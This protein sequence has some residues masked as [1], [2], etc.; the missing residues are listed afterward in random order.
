MYER[1]KIKH[2]TPPSD[3]FTEACFCSQKPGSDILFL[4]KNHVFYHHF[5]LLIVVVACY[6]HFFILFHHAYITYMCE[7]VCKCNFCVI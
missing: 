5:S 2:K 7:M 1:K 3:T 6:K 4:F